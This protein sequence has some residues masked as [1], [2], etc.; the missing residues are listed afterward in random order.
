MIRIKQKS[1]RTGTLAVQKYVESITEDISIVPKKDAW[2]RTHS[3]QT[4]SI[5]NNITKKDILQYAK[6]IA[7]HQ[8]NTLFVQ[9][10][11]SQK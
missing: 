1:L 7:I 9:Y 3:F 8:K 5:K 10:N 2:K 4:P 6:E 11:T